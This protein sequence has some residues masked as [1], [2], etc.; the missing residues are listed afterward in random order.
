MQESVLSKENKL[1]LVL[2]GFFIS[3][4]ILAELIGGKLFS[5][6][7]FLGIPQ[8]SWSIFGEHNISLTMTCGVILWPV[9]FVLTDIINE[10]FGIRGVR[11]LSYL[12]VGLISFAFL[13]L[14]FAMKLPGADFYRESMQSSGIKDMDVAFSAV[15]GQ[16]LWIIF[17]SLVAFLI[18]QIVDVSVFQM[19]RK[20]TGE[21]HLWLR[22]NLSTIIS[23]LIDSFVVLFIAFYLS[24][25]YPF[26]W[27]LA[28]GVVNFLY[29][30]IVALLLT[31]LLYI[32]HH[33]IDKYLGEEL[34]S[35]LQRI[36][37]QSNSSK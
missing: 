8:V 23:Q 7:K 36:A 16:S 33:V 4:A 21:Q 10:Y 25:K 26:N 29:K 24:G 22:A 30:A 35:K 37:S 18:G 13:A 20:R 5:V 17:G 9:V 3:N 34:S 32:V 12:A 6:E 27:V 15:F 14:Y 31:P 2:G 1:L 28:V 11:F 19:I